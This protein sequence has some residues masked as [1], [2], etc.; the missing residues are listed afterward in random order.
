MKSI[1]ALAFLSSFDLRHCQS[2]PRWHFRAARSPLGATG[3]GKAY[4]SFATAAASARHAANI[5]VF[6]SSVRCL[7]TSASCQNGGC[8]S[9]W[10]PVCTSVQET[11]CKSR[12]R[13]ESVEV[14]RLGKHGPAC[15]P[16]K[17]GGLE[18]G[19]ER[20]PGEKSWKCP[21]A[22]KAKTAV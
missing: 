19:R 14:G 22:H 13:E 11:L 8:N 10:R 1:S 17:L 16:S 4:C 21:S 9:L 5:D 15:R 20:G 3:I 18:G 12:V 7:G 2:C 6:G